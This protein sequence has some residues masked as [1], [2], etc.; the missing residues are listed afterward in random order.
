[1]TNLIFESDL[2]E[3]GQLHVTLE[4]EDGFKREMF[5]VNEHLQLQV[6]KSDITNEYV[7][8]VYPMVGGEIKFKFPI[9]MVKCI[10]ARKFIPNVT[11]GKLV[12]MLSVFKDTDEVLIEVFDDILSEDL[13]N[14]TFETIDMG[15]GN[16]EIR[17]CPYNHNDSGRMSE[18]ASDVEEMARLLDYI[19]LDVRNCTMEPDFCEEALKFADKFVNKYQ[20]HRA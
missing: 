14:F 8:M 3:S 19:G 4:N 15:N 9:A 11:K 12:E 7:G 17:L 18:M 5:E 6:T 1:M 2:F 20:T 10:S 16:S 13:Y